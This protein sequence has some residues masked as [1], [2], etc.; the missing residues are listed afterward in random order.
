MK[1]LEHDGGSKKGKVSKCICA[2]DALVYKI[3]ENQ[4]G[5][6][7][8][9]DSQGMDLLLKEESRKRIL[10]EGLDIQFPPE[11]EAS[12]TVILRN[13]DSLVHALSEEEIKDT[14]EDRYKIRRL[15]K[16]PNNKY[17]LKV[18]FLTAE[19]ADIA[20]EKGIS[21]S[22]QKF[23]GRNI[24]KEIFIPIVPCYRCYKYD[25][26]RKNCNKAIEYQ[27]CSNCSE[28]GHTYEYCKSNIARCINCKGNHR[29]LAA[30]CPVRKEIVRNK[31][32]ERRDKKKNKIQEDRFDRAELKVPENYLAVM[33]A[34]ITLA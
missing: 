22:F 13:V 33:A 30:R 29:T 31:I 24:D 25:H 8:V 19:A 17:L 21:I 32:R 6:I 2:A 28:E 3:R 12:C 5:F 1:V 34:A 14:A 4:D 20:I 7:L 27:I 11:Y 16:F 23:I 15:V 18:I 26:Q 9:T 10:D